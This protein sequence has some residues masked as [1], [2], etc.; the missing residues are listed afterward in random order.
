MCN[1]EYNSN[2]IVKY[3]LILLLRC[4][5]SVSLDYC[6]ETPVDRVELLPLVW[7]NCLPFRDSSVLIHLKEWQTLLTIALIDFNNSVLL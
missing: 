3:G 7:D 5:Q 4:F 1:E 2:R 6:L